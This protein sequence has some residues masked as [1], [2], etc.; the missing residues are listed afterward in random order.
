MP[1]P[2]PFFSSDMPAPSSNRKRWFWRPNSNRSWTSQEV[3]L[4]KAMP[5]AEPHNV[6]SIHIEAH[7]NPGVIGVPA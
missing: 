5:P 4:T 3:P 6:V 1:S 7:Q 2:S